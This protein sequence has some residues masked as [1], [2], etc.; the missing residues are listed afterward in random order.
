MQYPGAATPQRST[1]AS[2]RRRTNVR[3]SPGRF[4][5][6]KVTSFGS[7]GRDVH[8]TLTQTIMRDEILLAP[9]FR[10]QEE[11]KE[12]QHDGP[13]AYYPSP[14]YGRPGA[15]NPWIRKS[16]NVYIQD[17][18]DQNTD[19]WL[20]ATTVRSQ[21]KHTSSSADMERRRSRRP[22]SARP[23]EPPVASSGRLPK[24]NLTSR[25]NRPNVSEYTDKPRKTDRTQKHQGSMQSPSGSV[26]TGQ[27]S[28]SPRS[29]SIDAL[30][31]AIANTLKA[32]GGA[33]F[34]DEAVRSAVQ[35]S[36]SDMKDSGTCSSAQEQGSPEPRISRS[37]QD[38]GHDGNS[39]AAVTTE[40][41]QRAKEDNNRSPIHQV[42]LYNQSSPPSVS[43]PGDEKEYSD[44]TDDTD[45]DMAPTESVSVSMNT[46]Q[47]DEGSLEFRIAHALGAA[48]ASSPPRSH[49]K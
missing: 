17:T 6:Q 10:I 49:Q 48:R 23:A 27:M 35:K 43:A 1:S 28:A 2:S 8:Q 38:K 13:G 42:E 3:Q 40:G 34:S 37:I 19:S 5:R 45:D 41:S 24:R 30:S 46:A 14:V 32:E 15:S 18:M 31:R 36:L 20:R 25:F 22:V 16:H 9:P 47:H 7:T 44:D 11:E 12:I 4:P 29:Y 26:A 33:E 21:N 39:T